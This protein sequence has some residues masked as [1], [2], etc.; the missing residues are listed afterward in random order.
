MTEDGWTKWNPYGSRIYPLGLDDY[1]HVK[2]SSGKDDTESEP[3]TVRDWHNIR[4]FE[5]LGH[6]SDIVAYKRARPE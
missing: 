5:K 3:W 4:G 2:L 6:G 1:I